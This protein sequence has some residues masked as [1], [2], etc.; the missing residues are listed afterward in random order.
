MWEIP[1][2]PSRGRADASRFPVGP[3]RVAQQTRS[4]AQTL[5]SYR[6]TGSRTVRGGR[7][8]AGPGA[9]LSALRAW[10]RCQWVNAHNSSNIADRSPRE[11]RW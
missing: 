4:G 2:F 8:S 11:A 6:F 1:R 9:D 5:S 3:S 7:S 10:S